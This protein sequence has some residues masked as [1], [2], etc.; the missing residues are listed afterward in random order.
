MLNIK[1]IFLC[2]LAII[3]LSSF[4]N[5]QSSR[6]LLDHENKLA[7]Y[8]K[9]SPQALADNKI[10]YSFYFM[11]FD[12][13]LTTDQGK[14]M[15]RYPGFAQQ[16]L[17]LKD[18]YGN[19]TE[20]PD[21]LTI[22][23]AQSK[24]LVSRPPAE[25]NLNKFV[26][27]DVLK[28]ADPAFTHQKMITSADVASENPNVKNRERLTYIQDPA[29]K[30]CSGKDSFCFQARFEFSCLK[31]LIDT[32]NNIKASKTAVVNATN[33]VIAKL[34][35]ANPAPAPLPVKKLEYFFDLQ[36]EAVVLNGMD[37]NNKNLAEQLK[38]I[39]KV[40]SQVHSILIQTAFYSSDYFEFGKAIA[41]VQDNPT[42]PGTSIVS[43]VLI[44]ALKDSVLAKA[45]SV[46]VPERMFKLEDF[47]LGK[48]I[49]NGMKDCRG[50]ETGI[51]PY[52]KSLIS[53][54]ANIIDSK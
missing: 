52:T 48:T 24:F 53:N 14:L 13:W 30:W 35:M 25:L 29:K 46:P 23:G 44:S 50:I 45:K 17:K 37:P 10:H 36:S 2:G 32:Y 31:F 42:Q 28:K 27:L 5:A 16:K 4:A 7:E 12:H 9:L 20:A 39:T 38:N 21:N 26:N 43:L 15:N 54:M 19:E 51:V 33:N 11:K 41:V 8:E 1:R 22:F 49:L 18:A 47:L 40:P 3:T 34:P 6:S